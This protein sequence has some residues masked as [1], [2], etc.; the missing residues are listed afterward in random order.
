M[1]LCEGGLVDGIIFDYSN[2]MLVVLFVVIGGLQWKCLIEVLY[3]EVCGEMVCGLFVVGEVIFNCVVS[4]CYFDMLC[5]VINQG[6]GVC[7]VC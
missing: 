3:F 4:V 5:M 2:E 1:L 6:M 7:Y